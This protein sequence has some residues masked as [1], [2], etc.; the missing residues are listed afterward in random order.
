MYNFFKIVIVLVVA[1]SILAS[2]VS[3]QSTLPAF[4]GAEGFGAKTVG[5]RGGNVMKVTNTNDS[6]AG[7]LRACFEAS[8]PRI[9]VFTV[10]GV[11]KLKT[12]L[13]I[14]NPYI[15][16]AG[17]TSPGDGILITLDPASPFDSPLIKI[18]THDVIVRFLRLR[19][20]PYAMSVDN[21]NIVIEDG[22][23]NV[24]ID[25]NSL[26]WAID[27]NLSTYGQDGSG[28]NAAHDVTVSWNII[29]EGL[30][31][32]TH[33]EGEHSKGFLT[34]RSYNLSIHHNLFAHNFARNPKITINS[35][36]GMADV[37]NNVV[38]NYGVRSTEGPL[39][40]EP[41]FASDGRVN[42]IGNY[43][44]PGTDTACSPSSC[45]YV[46]GTKGLV[47]LQDNFMNNKT[48]SDQWALMVDSRYPPKR[49]STRFS[50]PWISNT[51]A[52][53]AYTEVTDK[54]GASLP[55][56]D[57]TDTRIVDE[58]KSK[59]GTIKDCVTRT[60]PSSIT[61]CSTS[62]RVVPEGWVSYSSGASPQD[63]DND[64]IPDDWEASHG[65]NISAN[66]IA[67]SGYTWIEEY[68]NSLVDNPTLPVQI[69]GDF[70]FD[71]HVNSEDYDI[72]LN[73]FGNPY[74]IFDYNHL[75][76]NYGKY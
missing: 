74:T 39:E 24:V 33:P 47:Y 22:S 41:D 43:I 44:I 27:E 55:R 71:G 58:V 51:L 37:I 34:K 3:S 70:N 40:I 63:S 1:A 72:L 10:G 73:N 76:G 14:R 46:T 7:S 12:G 45:F 68:V 62:N 54:A 13:K 17:Q 21:D 57:V 11:I 59:T 15:T 61:N 64:G 65:G 25:H 20:G 28:T 26:S 75:V 50:S 42:I 2:P 53:L 31:N 5:G 32:S 23:Y 29:A 60:D 48:G 35:D 30:S 4:P 69:K 36:L 9:C 49:S 18:T 56:R 38:Y 67:P 66:D 6:G 8:G 52:D 19:I 16:V